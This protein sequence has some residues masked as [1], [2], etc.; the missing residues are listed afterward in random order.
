MFCVLVVCFC[1]A[2]VVVL[3]VAPSAVYLGSVSGISS[4]SIGSIF[5]LYFLFFGGSGPRFWGPVNNLI[6]PAILFSS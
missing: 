4:V 5:L 1:F 3:S 6:N 2:C